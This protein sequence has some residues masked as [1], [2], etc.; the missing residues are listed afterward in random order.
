[1]KTVL[2]RVTEASCVIDGSVVGEIGQGYMILT[3][4][5]PTDTRD[6]VDRMIRKILALRVFSDEEGKMNRSLRD[7]EASVLNIS[8]F[9]L[10]ADCR[11]GNRPGFSQA[12]CPETAISL[13]NY[14]NEQ[15]ARQV[16]TATGRFG[17]D[18]QIHLVND[19]PVT[20]ELEMGEQ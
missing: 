11:K 12:A 10:Y 4:F 3:G 6:T 17:A 9:T 2:Q 5:C 13:Y 20:I 14:M 15:L 19:G 7:V 18:M 1:M 16:P 8:Q